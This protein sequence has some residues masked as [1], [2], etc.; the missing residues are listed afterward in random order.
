MKSIALNLRS[1]KWRGRRHAFTLVELM[2]SMVLLLAIMGVL[3]GLLDQ[4]SRVWLMGERRVFTDQNARAIFDL[5]HRDLA[6]AVADTRNQFVQIEASDLIHRIPN[7]A[8]NST[9]LFFMSPVGQFGEMCAIGYFLTRD[10]DKRHYRLNRLFMT[11]EHADFPR[12]ESFSHTQFTQTSS[13]AIWV[14]GETPT[15]LSKGLP[16]RVFELTGPGSA[17]SVISDGVLSAHFAC[18]DNFGN[19][20]PLASEQAREN[21]TL[22]FNSAA[23]FL[24]AD[25]GALGGNSEGIVFLSASGLQAHSVPSAVRVGLLISNPRSLQRAD[26][27][28][29][30]SPYELNTADGIDLDA[31]LFKDLTAI[32]NGQ[33]SDSRSFCETIVLANA[34]P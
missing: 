18:L 32:A 12:A 15:D 20:L 27:V 10:A 1:Q 3:L 31:T 33:L 4:T 22:L 13:R 30:I 25:T 26:T 16:A 7:I 29:E 6:P 23:R 2:V 28:P 17:T 19:P 34:N 14:T 21:T 5:M 24:L 11:P 9:A 8:P